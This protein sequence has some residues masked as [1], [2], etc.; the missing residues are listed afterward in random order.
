MA[1]AGEATVAVRRI[2]VLAGVSSL[3]PVAPAPSA[4]GSAEA[5]GLED[6]GALVPAERSQGAVEEM[7]LATTPRSVAQQMAQQAARITAMAG[8]RVDLRLDPEELGRVAMQIHTEGD[9]ITLTIA[10]ERGDTTELIRRHLQELA[11]E[12]RALGYRSVSLGFEDERGGD[13]TPSRKE[14]GPDRQN[15]LPPGEG[16]SAAIPHLPAGAPL[17]GLDLRL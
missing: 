1:G 17:M 4:P 2:S 11:G 8:G 3:R 5:P 13:G 10:A 16:P 7:R 6:W 15:P 14:G 9:R 12:L